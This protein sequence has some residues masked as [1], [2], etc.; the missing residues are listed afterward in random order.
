MPRTN[1]FIPIGKGIDQRLDERLRAPDSLAVLTNAEYR[2]G[3]GVQKRHGF[4]KMSETCISFAPPLVETGNVAN[5]GEPRSIFSTQSELC[6]RG[7]RSLYSYVSGNWYNKGAVSPFTGKQTTPLIDS[8]NYNSSDVATDGTVQVNVGTTNQD[9]AAS[10]ATAFVFTARNGELE[11]IPSTTIASSPGAPTQEYYNSARAIHNGNDFICSVQKQVI[12]SPGHL[13][14]YSTDGT[15]APSIPFLSF[16]NLAA[17]PFGG[18]NIEFSF[19]RHDSS[20]ISSPSSTANW[21][22]AYITEAPLGGTTIYL[23][24]YN[25]QT[26][27]NSMTFVPLPGFEWTT[28]TLAYGPRN[29]RIYLVGALQDALNNTA[30]L[31]I[32]INPNTL[33]TVSQVSLPIGIGRAGVVEAEFD[34]ATNIS[35]VASGGDTTYVLCCSTSAILTSETIYNVIPSTKPWFHGERLYVAGRPKYGEASGI[36]GGTSSNQNGYSGEVVFDL[37][38]PIPLG[39]TPGVPKI[40]PHIVARY[41]FGVAHEKSW[42]TLGAEIDMMRGACSN[43]SMQSASSYIYA[44]QRIV[45]SV[46]SQSPTKAG[47]VIELDY[48]GTMLQGATSRGTATIGGANVGWYAGRRV[49]EL[50][51]A[52]GPFIKSISYTSSPT[53][54]LTNGSYTYIGVFECYDEHGNLVRSVAGPPA[55]TII[56]GGGM[57]YVVDIRFYTLGATQRYVNE[58]TYKVAMYRAGVDGVFYRCTRPLTLANV[59]GTSDQTASIT[60]Y[61]NRY[62]PIYTQ[63]G[64]ELEAAG[65]DGAAFSVT[66]SQRVWLAGFFRRDRVQYSKLYNAATANEYALAPEFN[67]G[68]AYLTPGGQTITGLAEM[69]DKVVV[70]TNSSI[71]AIAGNGPD[72]GGRNNDFSGLQLINSDTGCIEPR[73]IVSFPGGVMFQTPSGIFVLGRDLQ[74][75]F[76]GAQVREI[77]EEFSEVTSAT[78]VPSANH[79]RFTL[80]KDGSSSIVLCYDLDQGAWIRWEP[81][82]DSGG[83]PVALNI[84]GSCL[85]DNKHYLLDADG[86]VWFEDQTTFKDDGTIFVPMTIETGWLQGAGQSGYQRVRTVAALCKSSDPHDLT[87]SA[88]QDFSSSPSQSYT[89]PAATIALQKLNELV[90]LRTSTQKCTAFKIRITDSA[91]MTTSTGEGYRCSGFAVEL[92]GKAGLYKPGTQQRN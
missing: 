22:F 73:S 45:Q 82:K 66:T 49:E 41:N 31:L 14:F 54:T 91:A 26:L 63:S 43:V 44:T 78:L 48:S 80:R 77:T 27:V 25:D 42:Y 1:A 8:R 19:A 10:Y 84:V 36:P 29:D 83:T 3:D 64:A 92:G 67:D 17:D 89:W 11:T 79:V 20:P 38:S 68:F 52:S 55:Q 56:S 40:A 30:S 62:D 12:P 2:R 81:R 70:F 88:Y 76:L 21:M 24:T 47:D 13:Y 72:D 69:D 6:V 59:P 4:T 33:A 34:S 85:H 35:I 65:P 57:S 46:E 9:G 90:E 15:S 61:G 58:K 23:A 74:L 18:G 75:T 37:W 7:Y 86:T 32:V 39:I 71:Y 50:G 28:L 16:N 60:D 5:Q 87:I 51:Y 53:G